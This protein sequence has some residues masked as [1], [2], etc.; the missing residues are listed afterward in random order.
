MNI[1][2]IQPEGLSEGGTS[3]AGNVQDNGDNDSLHEP[4]MAV[5]CARQGRQDGLSNYVE[6]LGELP[7]I[8]LTTSDI[9]VR[10]S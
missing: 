1:A 7:K 4:K 8:C 3:E 6:S 10:L 2:Y 5:E 9:L